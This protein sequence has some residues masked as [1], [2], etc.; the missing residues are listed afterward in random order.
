MDIRNQSLEAIILKARGYREQDQLLTVVSVENGP[1]SVLARGARKAESPLR[2]VC[3]PYSRACLLL[4][5][6]KGG[7]RFLAEGSPRESYILPES[8]LSAFAYAAYLAEL[9]LAAWP[10][11]KPAPELYYLAQAAFS[12]LKLD[13]DHARTARFFELRLLASLG[14]LPPADALRSCSCC[15]QA[16]AGRRFRLSPQQGALL[17]EACSQGDGA[18]LISAGAALSLHRLLT[19]PLPRIPAI[20]LRG[21]VA[22]ELEQAL[23]YYLRYH[24]EYAAKAKRLLASLLT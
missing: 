9:L 8:S 11:Q 3:Q 10:P 18:P 4:T 14:W 21:A 15:G 20:R 7:L 5:P 12:L 22:D 2:S 13:E 23:E 6:A 19:L 16:P 17:C 24:L 1:E